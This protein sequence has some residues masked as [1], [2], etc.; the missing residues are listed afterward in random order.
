MGTSLVVESVKDYSSKN[1]INYDTTYQPKQKTKYVTNKY[2]QVKDYD[3]YYDYSSSSNYGSSNYGSSHS[4]SGG[5]QDYYYY[6]NYSADDNASTTPSTTTTTTTTTTKFFPCK[7]ILYSRTHF[8]GDSLEIET[9]T[10][11]LAFKNFDDKLASLDVE[12]NCCWEIFVDENFS[13]RS[14]K[15]QRQGRFPSAV[16]LQHIFQKAS[17]VK[18]C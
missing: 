3:E 11:S 8:R 4:S 7:L 6:D 9:D 5:Y 18:E 17:S 10:D 16:D 1:I 2:G 15:F 12:G 14:M 13:G